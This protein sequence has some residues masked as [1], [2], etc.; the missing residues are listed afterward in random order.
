MAAA[1]VPSADADEPRPSRACGGSRAA[2]AMSQRQVLQGRASGG[3]PDGGRRELGK[4]GR[5]A[6]PRLSLQC[7]SST[8]KPAPSSCRWWQSWRPD[9][10][11]SRLCRMRVSSAP[12]ALV[13]KGPGLA[14]PRVLGPASF[15]TRIPRPS[16]PSVPCPLPVP[17]AGSPALTLSL[18]PPA[19]FCTPPHP[20]PLWAELLGRRRKRMEDGVPKCLQTTA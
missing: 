8:R 13:T 9:P 4:T 3:L 19:T 6:P 14:L 16:S 2:R 1:V 18:P 12:P 5:P 15:L 10:K 7:S 11:T 20:A 17:S